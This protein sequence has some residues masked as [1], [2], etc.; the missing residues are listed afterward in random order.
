MKQI[1][2]KAIFILIISLTMTEVTNANVEVNEN[3]HQE[4]LKLTGIDILKFSDLLNLSRI[5]D[6]KL[7]VWIIGN[8]ELHKEN[9]TLML[10]LIFRYTDGL[11]CTLRIAKFK[12]YND[13]KLAW[14]DSRPELPKSNREYRKTLFSGESI[15]NSEIKILD[16]ECECYCNA[17]IFYNNWLCMLSFVTGERKNPQTDTF[18]FI[19]ESDHKKIDELIKKIIFIIDK[20]K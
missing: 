7:K 9:K 15:P 17:Y 16:H 11:A 4:V 20:I 2:I 19:N 1:L 18:D 5:D 8:D 14:R 10:N 6:I 13:S 12:S 3:I